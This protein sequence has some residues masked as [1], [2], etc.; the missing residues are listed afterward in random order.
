MATVTVYTAARMKK[1][2]DETVIGGS[3][4]GDNL[5]LETR[6]GDLINAGDVRGPQG[7]QGVPGEVTLA[8]LNTVDNKAIQAGSDAAAAAALA[9][10]AMAIAADSKIVSR[11]TITTPDNN[12]IN[13]WLRMTNG[14]QIVWGR[15]IGSGS[16]SFVQMDT[17]YTMQQPVFF[18]QPFL[19][20]TIPI[21][22]LAEA[23]HGTWGATW[24]QVELPEHRAFKVRFWATSARGS[25]NMVLSFQAIGYYK[26]PTA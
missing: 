17:L 26:T 10:S 18:L 13:H 16:P 9:N 22:T 25:A 5:I 19:A 20:D 2:E 3:I 14:I 4:D 8:Q 7:P 11:G 12:Y 24:G 23:W 6:E 21:I 15:F 1:I